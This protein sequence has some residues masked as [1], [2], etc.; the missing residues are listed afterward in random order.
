MGFLICYPEKCR[1]WRYACWKTEIISE[2]S[3]RIKIQ[4]NYF[5]HDLQKTYKFNQGHSFRSN[6]KPF[7]FVIICIT[8]GNLNWLITVFCFFGDL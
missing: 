8:V 7:S 5:C 3:K 6:R 2:H 1:P 4:F